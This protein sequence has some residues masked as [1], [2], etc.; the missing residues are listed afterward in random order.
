MPAS[1]PATT[2][3]IAK[4]VVTAASDSVPGSTPGK[5]CGRPRTVGVVRSWVVVLFD[6]VVG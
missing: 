6:D 2:E 5:V 4:Q 1:S 3:R